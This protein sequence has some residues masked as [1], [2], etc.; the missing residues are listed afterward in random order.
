M[1]QMMQMMSMMQQSTM[2]MEQ[3]AARSSGLKIFERL[4]DKSSKLELRDSPAAESS[5]VQNDSPEAPVLPIE[6]R[7]AEAPQAAGSK[8]EG[9]DASPAPGELSVPWISFQHALQICKCAL[10][11]HACIS[12]VY[13]TRNSHP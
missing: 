3:P 8:T 7:K 9:S 12:Q 4:A 1:L 10:I 2:Q 11:H 13:V 5:P 6:D